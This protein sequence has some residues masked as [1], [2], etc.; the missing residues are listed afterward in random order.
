MAIT[1]NDVRAKFPDYDDLSDEQLA[2][3]LHGKYYSDMAQ[4]DFYSAIGLGQSGVQESPRP[5]SRPNGPGPEVPT[6]ITGQGP[7]P[8]LTGKTEID[9]LTALMGAS[10]PDA[11]PTIGAAPAMSG[12]GPEV[13]FDTTTLDAA[14]KPVTDPAMKEQSE[15]SALMSDVSP[16]TAPVIGSAPDMSLA[17]PYPNQ[18]AVPPGAPMR[19]LETAMGLRPE[20]SPA[21]PRDYEAEALALAMQ[22]AMPSDEHAAIPA[23]IPEGMTETAM[24][25]RPTHSPAAPRDYEAE[26]RALMETQPVDPFEG[27]GIGPLAKRR[28]QQFVKGA[29]EVVATVPESIAITGA[30]A[31]AGRVEGASGT[32][33]MRAQTIADMEARIADPAL[34]P[35]DRAIIQRNLIDMKSGQDVIGA[36]ANAPVVPA[37]ER[38]VFKSGDAIRKAATD[39]FGTP[40]P[41][42]QSFWAGVSEG[43]GNMTGMIAASTAGTVVGGPVGGLVVGG[44]S[45]SAMNQSQVYKEALQGGADEATAM[46]ASKWA[47][48]IGASEIIPINRALKLLPPRLRG[49]LST[50]MM[51][52]FV[53]LAQGAG[54]EAAQEYLSQ[55][56]NNITAQNLYD[57]ER[58]WTE[59]AAESALIGAV[60]GTAVAAGGLALEGNGDA[61]PP[62]TVPP[63]AKDTPPLTP[64]QELAELLASQPAQPPAA[65]SAQ[66]TAPTLEAEIAQLM[67]TAPQ[68]QD[69]APAQPAAPAQDAVPAQP[70]AQDTA[71]AAPSPEAEIAQLMGAA[72]P[73]AKPVATAP[74]PEK[75][76]APPKDDNFTIMDEVETGPNGERVPTGRKV[77]I[78]LTTGQATV[79]GADET[80]AQAG[81]APDALTGDGQQPQAPSAPVVGNDAP[82]AAGRTPEEEIA[83]TMTPQQVAVSDK[84]AQVDPDA[85]P[86]VPAKA[87]IPQRVIKSDKAATPTGTQID[88]DYAIVSLDSLTASNSDDGRINPKYPQERQPR[89]RTDGKSE[90]QNSADHARL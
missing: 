39:T 82:P 46:E 68:A 2:E 7:A 13:P 89:D 5:K 27:E 9:E 80:P 25:L 11:A 63:R 41:R 26:A 62:A 23:A 61:V 40:D 43:A 85:V 87:E 74:T 57:P 53:E 12:P 66:G 3:A 49:E 4:Q 70:P 67:G 75:P 38:D 19:V 47:V 60:L 20:R 77:R 31:D 73:E 6:D 35:E 37:S 56:A 32:L 15:L 76:D 58:G 34:R 72:P 1:I 22:A 84:P 55:V 52:K 33:D 90:Q 42:D 44:A 18:P 50:G 79:I 14:R 54:E 30:V 51:R 86:K 29:T 24:G 16:D 10:Q 83:A 21:A 78:D 59:G 48:L 81:G 88:V 69:T 45:G 8:D 28:G 64:E 65:Q 17:R 71:P 36:M